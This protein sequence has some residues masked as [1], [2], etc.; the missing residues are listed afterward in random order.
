MSTDQYN[1]LREGGICLL[2][3]GKQI[4][5]GDNC[6]GYM[7][8]EMF[9]ITECTKCGVGEAS[10]KRN[11]GDLYNII[12]SDVTRV[13]G[14]ARYAQYGDSVLLAK[15]PLRYLADSE[16]C[17][18]GVDHFLKEV[19]AKARQLVIVEIGSGLGYLTYSLNC[20]GYRATG[21]DCSPVAVGSARARYGANY[22]CAD[23]GEYAKQHAGT[24]DIV[25]LTEVIEHIEN[26]LEF[27]ASALQ[28]LRN[29]GQLILS[30][31]NK[32]LYPQGSVWESELPPIHWWWFTESSM[33]K[34]A[35]RLG[36]RAKFVDL[37]DFNRVKERYI[38]H[39]GSPRQSVLRANGSVKN[40]AWA[41][42]LPAFAKRFMHSVGRVRVA[43]KL[44]RLLKRGVALQSRGTTICALYTKE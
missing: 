16:E 21:L 15:N 17:Y 1:V 7:E 35:E 9:V 38:S 26:P 23:I 11:A 22:V 25:I 40:P 33:I 30:T 6:P 41:G 43:R 3:G 2:C 28:L 13:P 27:L 39:G 14:Y 19:D 37:T 34:M 10:P 29:R 20:A 36:C 24:A 32:S 5:I 18:W 4:L 8:G 31:P 42:G 44:V 12:Y